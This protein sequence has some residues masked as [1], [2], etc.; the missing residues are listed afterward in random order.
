MNRGTRTLIVVAVAILVAT[1]ATMAVYNAVRQIPERVVEREG[2]PVV[3]AAK[4]LPIGTKLSPADLR[5][6][7]WPASNPVTGAF[8]T[9]EAVHLEHFPS[10]E[11][12]ADA[13]AEVFR[14]LGPG[15]V[16]VIKRDNP[17]THRLAAAARACGARVVTFGTGLDAGARFIAIKPDADGAE[18]QAEV[19][20]EILAFRV[21]AP[22]KHFNENALAVLAAIDAAG[23]DARIS[24]EALAGFGAPAGRGARQW[25]ELAD[26]RALLIDESY[27]A[28]P[29]SMRAALAAM[30]W[31]PNSIV[32][33][34][35]VV[36][37]EMLELGPDARQLHEGL[38]DAL[39]AA[40]V[41]LVFACG[42]NMRH[43]FERLGTSRRGAWAERSDGLRQPLLECIRAG[44]VIM[45][46]GS[47]GA[48]LSVLV[49]A[50]KAHGEARQNAAGQT[51][52]PGGA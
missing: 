34:R 27:N 29:A 28:N 5:V 37:G 4:S 50:L 2:V 12:I 26:G 25:L 32:R 16:A 17:H 21:G 49:E 10:V 22:G 11:A 48:R 3:V 6:A 51:T 41:D 20:G 45:L 30:R 7:V 44:D 47:N 31:L 39:D 36:L 38:I 24:A 15:G 40:H 9:V 33:R 18:L 35:V 42:P 14:G 43:L 8:T 46:K 1:L 23:L 13:K 52:G 19:G